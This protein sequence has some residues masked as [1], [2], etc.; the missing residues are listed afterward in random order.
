MLQ[1]YPFNIIW[2]LCQPTAEGVDLPLKHPIRWISF[3][4]GYL[5]IL[6][7]Q[8]ISLEND[9]GA[10]KYQYLIN[11]MI[12]AAISSENIQRVELINDD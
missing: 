4:I 8:P 5:Q 1:K 12:G 11:I 9:P 10:L 3:T 7:Y 6:R 2:K